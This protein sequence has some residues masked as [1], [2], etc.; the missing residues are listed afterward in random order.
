MSTYRKFF[1]HNA[2]IY[3]LDDAALV[4]GL[5]T[6]LPLHTPES[7]VVLD[8]SSLLDSVSDCFVLNLYV[9]FLLK[10]YYK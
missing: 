6:L 5:V 1:S 7:D 9:S 3:L 2:R 8:R 10:E 4:S